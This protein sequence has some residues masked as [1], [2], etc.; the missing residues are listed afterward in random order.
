MYLNN[1]ND[2]VGVAFITN[3]FVEFNDDT[4]VARVSLCGYIQVI[5]A[6]IA[7]LA[8]ATARELINFGPLYATIYRSGRWITLLAA[9]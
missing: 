7:V 4:V 6:A 2:G 8:T 9:R 1:E 5:L 3:E